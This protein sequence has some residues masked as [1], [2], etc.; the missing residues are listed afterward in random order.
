MT[1]RSGNKYVSDNSVSDGFVE[2]VEYHSEDDITD[3]SFVEFTDITPEIGAELER[4][5]LVNEDHLATKDVTTSV[6]TNVE[7][8]VS[9][10]S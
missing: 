3:E 10:L 2:K 6:N 8:Q 7:E 5:Q 9:P 1:L 4:T